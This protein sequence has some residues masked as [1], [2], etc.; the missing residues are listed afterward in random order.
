MTAAVSFAATALLLAAAGD[1]ATPMNELLPGFH[2]S[3][4]FG[5]QVKEQWIEGDVR[6]LVNVPADFAPIRLTR[7]IGLRHAERRHD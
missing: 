6:I 1:A 2:R 7:L 4:W 5:E 3:P